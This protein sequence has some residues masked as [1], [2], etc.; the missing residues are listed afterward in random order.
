LIL[1]APL[2][3]AD[4]A[5][6]FTAT[7]QAL[8]TLWAEVSL[9]SGREVEGLSVKRLRITLRAAPEGSTM[10]PKPHQRLR[11][12]NRVYLIDTVHESD[13]G[14]RYLSCLAREEVVA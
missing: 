8:G 6:G 9:R 5:G 1:E 13:A 4:G 11:E 2:G 3:V 14:A 7:W 10:R 12:G